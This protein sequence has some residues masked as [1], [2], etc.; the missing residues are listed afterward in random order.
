MSATPNQ[1]LLN[2]LAEEKALQASLHEYDKQLEFIAISRNERRQE[3]ARYERAQWFGP[4]LNQIDVWPLYSLYTLAIVGP[5]SL[6]TFGILRAFW[7]PT[8]LASIGAIITA[9]AAIY[10]GWRLRSVEADIRRRFRED[11]AGSIRLLQVEFEDLG[12][13]L[14]SLTQRREAAQANLDDLSRRK[15]LL[16]QELAAVYEKN[17]LE[18]KVLREKDE[19]DNKNAKLQLLRSHWEQLRGI[20]FEEFLA[21]VLKTHG[22]QVELTQASNDQGVDL[23]A[24]I[25]GCRVAIQAK[26]YSNPVGNES[27]QQVIAGMRFYRCTKAAVITNS[28]FT[29]SALLLAES[30]ECLMIDAKVIPSLIMHGW[31]E[32][33]VRR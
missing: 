10:G 4:V 9:L 6:L 16:E 32:T 21:S 22:Y 20:P 12:S 15:Q 13:Q 14:K 2:I 5:G 19:R 18:E 29:N 8:W 26:G 33:G 30:N 27:V 25:A 23:I 1:N 11:V 17:K 7:I 31:P 24:V 3:K 28:S